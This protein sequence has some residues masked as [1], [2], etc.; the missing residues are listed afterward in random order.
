M[1]GF[2]SGNAHTQK[3][4]RQIGQ[5][6]LH[7]HAEKR[8]FLEQIFTFENLVLGF[9]RGKWRGFGRG[10]MG[11]GTRMHH[12]WA[13]THAVVGRKHPIC[14]VQ[15]SGFWGKTRLFPSPF[16]M[17]R[18][19]REVHAECMSLYCRRLRK[20]PKNSVFVSPSG[21]GGKSAS[22][23]SLNCKVIYCTPTALGVTPPCA[24]ICGRTPA[25]TRSRAAPKARRRGRCS[26]KGGQTTLASRRSMRQGRC[27]D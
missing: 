10:Y 9:C 8:R 4:V 6:I 12:F 25:A 27:R 14:E 19:E 22:I 5:P 15:T 3:Q 21:V 23:S 18:V 7:T 13:T 20:S 2:Q 17:F 16:V 26:D 1:V 24:R 11:F